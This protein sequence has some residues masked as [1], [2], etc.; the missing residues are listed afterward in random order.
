MRYEGLAR[1]GVL[2]SSGRAQPIEATFRGGEHL[3]LGPDWEVEVV[4]L[5]GHFK[6]HLGVLDPRNGGLYG[7]D[8]IQGSVYLDLQGHPAMPPTYLHVDDYLNTVRFI[9]HLPVDMYVGCHWPVKRGSQVRDFCAE[10][11]GFVEQADHLLREYL[12][13][14]HTLREACLALGPQ[15]GD[16]PHGGAADFDLMYALGGHVARLVEGG[17]ARSSVRQESPRVLEFSMT[18]RPA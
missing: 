4:A 16:W 2:T 14:P 12:A 11:R 6:G 17:Q 13:E 5:P 7:A 18:S 3:R 9:E 8:A 10:T 1:E 15:L